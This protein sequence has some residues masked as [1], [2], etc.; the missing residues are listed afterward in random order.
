MRIGKSAKFRHFG[1]SVLETE[2]I[3]DTLKRS[4]EVDEE[5]LLE[6]ESLYPGTVE[7]EFPLPC[8][9]AF[10]E[11]FT[12]ESWIKIK[13]IIK[14]MKNRRGRKGLRV[15][16]RFCGIAHQVA[17]ASTPIIVFPLVSKGNRQF[18]ISL[19]K[20]EYMLEIVALQLASLPSDTGGVWYYYDDITSKWS[21]REARSSGLKYFFKNDRWEEAV[22]GQTN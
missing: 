9:E 4:F 22:D 12:I 16:L 1:L 14:E 17:N 5:E 18:E 6:D 8:S 20:I 13:G 15:L 19:E 7:I 2:L 10:F 11:I 3:Y 21:P